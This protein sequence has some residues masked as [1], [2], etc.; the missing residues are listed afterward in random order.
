M[1][2]IGV[3][4]DIAAGNQV[5]RGN[6]ALFVILAINNIIIDISGTFGFMIKFNES[7][8]DIKIMIPYIIK[9]SPIRLNAIVIR[10][11]DMVVLFW[12]IIIRQIEE[13]PRPSHPIIVDEMSLLH[14]RII[15]DKKKAMVR[16]INFFLL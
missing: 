5:E 2:E 14:E 11:F 3:G 15:I 7:L 10:E 1:A 13:I 4:A 12:Y 8:F 16:E 6:C 9:M